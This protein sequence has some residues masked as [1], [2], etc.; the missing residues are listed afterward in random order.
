M[1]PELKDS[2][3]SLPIAETDNKSSLERMGKILRE[4]SQHL[5][6]K[7]VETPP[8]LI[9]NEETLKDLDTL[10]ER[11]NLEVK[12][13]NVF[14]KLPVGTMLNGEPVKNCLVPGGSGGYYDHGPDLSISISNE[15]D[16]LKREDLG[17]RIAT[18]YYHAWNSLL[19]PYAGANLI[20]LSKS[21]NNPG[22]LIFTMHF[23]QDKKQEDGRGNP[24]L[25]YVSL[26]F[27]N[28]V[29]TKL[30]KV[31]IRKP[32]FLEHLYQKC[33]KGLDSAEKTLG[34][35]RV[36]TTG[37]Y[38]IPDNRTEITDKITNWSRDRLIDFLKTLNRFNFVGGPYGSGDNL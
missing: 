6:P 25:A 7:T 18:T 20:S 24:T 13:R 38:F 36:K 11:F 30:I 28:A 2:T 23:L 12:A 27:T 4:A 35:R 31:L 16:A 8:P 26:E 10:A 19:P 33:F 3:K 17:F 15:L 29:M 1:D 22:N 5:E 34:M 37:F 21:K 14:G 32:D 9:V